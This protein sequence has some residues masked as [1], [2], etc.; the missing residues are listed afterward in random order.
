MT[1][2]GTAFAWGD[3]RF[4]Q[5]GLPGR[6]EESTPTEVGAPPGAPALPTV[7]PAR[8]STG[9]PAPGW[10]AARPRPQVPGL[11][12]VALLACGGLH[13]LA[14]RC[15][16]GLISLGTNQHGEL[17]AGRGRPQAASVPA[18]V[19]RLPGPVNSLAAGWKHSA[20]VDAAGQLWTWGWGGSQ[21]E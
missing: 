14:A 18:P 2:E 15:G 16:G 11:P 8:P 1:E 4:G 13:T 6:T 3:G 7:L 9:R 21:G 12:R 20:A 19:T 5:T 10:K 17:G